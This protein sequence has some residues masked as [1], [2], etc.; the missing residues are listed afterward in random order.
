MLPIQEQCMGIRR[1]DGR[2]SFDC[3]VRQHMLVAEP[4]D[5]G[6]DEPPGGRVTRRD[7][8][9]CG[10]QHGGTVGVKRP[11]KEGDDCGGRA[12]R[13]PPPAEAVATLFFRG[14]TT[15]LLV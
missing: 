14:A 10:L 8:A 4:C 13:E 11:L 6:A 3:F 5:L 9:R 15:Q 12:G 2:G 7:G 1:N